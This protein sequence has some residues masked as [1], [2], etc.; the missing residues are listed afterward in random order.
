MKDKIFVVLNLFGILLFAFF[1]ARSTVSFVTFKV[2]TLKY[3][4]QI[5]NK[6]LQEKISNEKFIVSFDNALQIINVNNIEVVEFIT[7]DK[8]DNVHVNFILKNKFRI[9]YSDIPLLSA[10]QNIEKNL[11]TKNI[12]YVWSNN[13]SRYEKYSS[14]PVKDNIELIPASVQD[15]GLTILFYLFMLYYLSKSMP[16]LMNEKFEVIM[17]DKIEGSFDDLVGLDSEIKNEILQLKDLIANK[18]LYASYG[19]KD[20]FNIVFSGPAGTGKTRTAL[21]LAKELGLPMVIGTGN[22]ETGLVGGGS[23]TIKSLFS[24][25]ESLAYMSEFKTSIIFLDEAQTLFAKR[26]GSKEKW[27]DDSANELLAQLDGISSTREISIIFIAASNFDDSNMNIDEAM[28]RRFKKKIFFRLPSHPERKEVIEF[29]LSKIDP[30]R[31]IE[32]NSNY[33]AG[34]TAGLSPAKI[35]TIINEASF[36]SIRTQSK[37]D[38]NMVFNAFEKIAIGHTNR[39][40]DNDDRER[41]VIHEIGHFICEYD[42]Y[43]QEGL[44]IDEIKEKTSFLKISSESISKFGALGYVLN[45]GENKK[46]KTRHRLEEDIVSLYGGYAA[47]SVFFSDSNDQYVSTG[48][49]ND[50]EK[51][52]NLLKHMICDIG[53]YSASKINYG[54]LELKNDTALIYKITEVADKLYAES[55][56][57]IKNNI[58][59]I[60]HLRDILLKEWVLNKDEIFDIIKAFKNT[61]EK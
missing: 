42:G 37:I 41:I 26:G 49:S 43:V 17:P 24:E 10:S 36:I 16:G 30:E 45:S 39:E 56:F 44:S 33:I 38:T 18:E 53:M 59:L 8:T 20:V 51:V 58:P 7:K 60:E 14:R 13:T 61:G 46:L 48:G 4:K 1:V 29:Y 55:K 52:S 6:K 34:I 27:A 40:D 28:E 22:I 21:F 23:N 31:I 15:N 5:E 11:L 9:S 19:L 25:A 35:E 54:V 50:I 12:S 47:E 2:D 57:R 32:V 3:D